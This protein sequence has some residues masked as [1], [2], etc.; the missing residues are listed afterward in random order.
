[1][2]GNWFLYPLILHFVRYLA[3]PLNITP[4]LSCPFELLREITNLTVGLICT[5][6]FA[7]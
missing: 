6:I 3:R 4:A 5:G 7:L 1:L 2:P